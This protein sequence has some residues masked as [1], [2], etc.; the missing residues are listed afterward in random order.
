LDF[1]LPNAGGDELPAV[2]PSGTVQQH[3]D[4]TRCAIIPVSELD[5]KNHRLEAVSA[6]HTSHVTFKIVPA[7]TLPERLVWLQ[8]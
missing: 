2:D 8:A 4:Q 3:V 5:V 7:S 6:R 1:H